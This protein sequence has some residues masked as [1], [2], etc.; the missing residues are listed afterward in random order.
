MNGNV[1]EEVTL[2]L[3]K[4]NDLEQ[5]KKRENKIRITDIAIKKVQYIE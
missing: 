2:L 1:S 5:A 4:G 3:E